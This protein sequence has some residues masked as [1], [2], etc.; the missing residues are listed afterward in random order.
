MQG[1]VN[2]NCMPCARNNKQLSLTKA[3]ILNQGRNTISK[4][5]EQ[6]W[7]GWCFR[8]A[9]SPQSLLRSIVCKEVGSV[10]HN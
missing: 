5:K 7:E 10:L 8:L 3:M 2:R 6:E 4:G 9:N 1:Q